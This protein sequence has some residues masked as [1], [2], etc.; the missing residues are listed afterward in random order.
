MAK[1]TL[2]YQVTSFPR[3]RRLMV[4]GGHMGRRKHL[5]HGL[6][7]IDVSQPHKLL[8]EHKAMTGEALSFTGFIMACVGRAIEQ[9]KEMQAYRTWREKLVIFDDVDINTIFEV[10]VEGRKIIRPHIIRATNRK[11]FLEIHKEIR[12]FQAGHEQGREAKLIDYFVLLPAFI[13]R[14]ML[15]ML[16]KNPHWVKEMSGTVTLSAFGMFADG[17]GWGIPVSNHTLQ[18][19]LGGLAEKPVIVNGR[20][21]NREH[22]CVTITID[23][24]L[25]DGAPAARFAR[26]LKTLIEKS[27]GLAEYTN[28]AGKIAFPS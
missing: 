17:A 2:N 10:E 13:R 11:S 20:V 25:V 4:D 21:E 1:N 23:H 6:F 14:F 3:D 22:L 19:T 8:R 7:E 18:I 26:T 9:N 27:D 5:V 28:D 15:T 12:A 16:F 24:D